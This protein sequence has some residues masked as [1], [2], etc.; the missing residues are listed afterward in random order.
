MNKRMGYGIG[1]V[2]MV[3]GF[4]IPT[5]ASASINDV[6]TSELEDKRIEVSGAA[7]RSWE[8][9]DQHALGLDPFG[10][11]VEP[12]TSS[13]TG[14]AERGWANGDQYTLGVDPFG[15]VVE[16]TS[17]WSASAAPLG[18][19]ALP[20]A[21]PATVL[22]VSPSYA[23]GTAEP[24]A[25][26]DEYGV[27]IEPPSLWHPSSAVAAA[28]QTHGL[29]RVEPSALGIN[30]QGLLEQA[31]PAIEDSGNLETNAYGFDPYGGVVEK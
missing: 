1:L 24:G 16:P 5:T 21:G 25:Y 20:D 12:N 3:T 31:R 22:R 6:N 2:L 8:N 28:T 17:P 26:I 9:G 10:G 7:N 13:V 19:E 15:G 30:E 29:T 4:G 27:I 11:F 14:A 23:L 18:S